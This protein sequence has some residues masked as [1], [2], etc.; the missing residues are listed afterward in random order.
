MVS[1]RLVKR[2]FTLALLTLFL[3]LGV[4]SSQQEMVPGV[5]F[6]SALEI[7]PGT[8]SFHLAV[9]E[10]HFFSIQLEPG[11]ILVA[12]IRMASNQDFDLYLFNPLREIVAQSVRVAGLTDSVEYVVTEK[13][14]HYVVVVGFADTEGTYTLTISV[15]KP[16]TLTQT[17]TTTVTMKTTE[18]VT[19]LALVTNTVVSEHLITQVERTTVEV[20]KIPWTAIGLTAV[21]AAVIY[22]GYVVSETTRKL[23]KKQEQGTEAQTNT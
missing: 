6:A 13:G 10:I 5:G 2:V 23:N 18:T 9:G 8:Y 19:A 11:E 12:K 21:G 3:V 15:V 16:K 22:A 20:E 17:V 7:S 4:A 14:P 1:L